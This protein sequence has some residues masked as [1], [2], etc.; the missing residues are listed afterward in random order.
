[1]D[2]PVTTEI[3][4]N[5]AIVT[6]D[7]PPVNAL[8]QAVRQGLIAQVEAAAADD[9]I[10]AIIITGAGRTFPAGAD[11][12]EF[13]APP[14]EPG[15]PDVCNRIEAVHKPVIAAIHGTALGGGLEV[16]LGSHFRIA[17]PSARLGLPEVHL[18]ILAGAGGTQRLTRI[19]G[20]AASLDIMTTGAPISAEKGVA[21]GVIDRMANVDLLADALAYAAE[22]VANKTVISRTCD[23]TPKNESAADRDAAIAAMRDKLAKTA[24]GLF[25]PFKIVDCVQAAYDRPFAAGLK[26]ERQNFAEC[27]A[28]PQCKGL[29]H[30]FFAERRSAKI[31]E[32]AR[33]KPR[34][35][36][37]L[38]VVGG[39]TM[40]AGITV[41]A[42][43]A[44]LKVTMVER[45]ADS[46]ARGRANVEKVY[47]RKISRGRMD[48]A[49]KAGI[50]DRYAGSTAYA[51][52]SDA[53]MIIEAVFED[54][55]VKKAVFAELDKV[56]KAGA[57]LASN[58]SYLNIDEIATATKRPGD[59]LGLH[60][61][62]PANIMRLLE[63]VV[64]SGVS[65]DAVATGFA[66]AK[67]MRKVPVRAAN[68]DGFIGNR[69]LSVYAQTA[70]HMME[71]GASPYAID[72]ALRDFGYPMG[73]F[74]V[75]DLAGNDIGWANR[76]RNAA[77]RDPN[78]RYVE[79]AD[80]ICENGWFGQK[81]GR[82]F[83]NYPDGVRIGVENPELLPIIA[84]EQAK[85][86]ITPREFS[87]DEIIR[88]YLA[89]MINAGANVLYSKAALRPS[90]IDVTLLFGYGFPRF[91]GGPMKYADH[92]GL[93][94]VLADV[95]EFEKE[96]PM[97]WTPSPLLVELVE[98][99]ADFDSLN[100]Q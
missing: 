19:T 93:D 91:R 38:G 35:L 54:M 70:H 92:I 27:L 45:N 29:V 63:I 26:A 5:I 15:L 89:A 60:F 68:Q 48:A 65:D 52:L 3:R 12:R 99:G 88:R 30:A 51:D 53:D 59:V 41:A 80:R 18:G 75:S 23:R 83:Y 74:Q 95:R 2:D 49:K 42:L 98:K 22:I 39:G 17:V 20:A 64:P 43:D 14:K 86:G 31:P 84:A 90:D 94:N 73:V 37:L 25:S 24:K 96:D 9:A 77:T 62:S 32:A 79:I 55:A 28:T 33:A 4:G 10:A 46:I 40:G 72:A 71:D 57:V 87:A 36:G 66:L 16:A 69:M 8:G 61:F 81:T 100:N 6:I 56:A 76:K 1:M 97:F 82:G 78:A 67:M 7:N 44:G 21:L 13:G 11:I 50:M 58:T 34:A 85:K 47:D